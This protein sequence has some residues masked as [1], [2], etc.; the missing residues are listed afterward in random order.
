MPQQ[1]WRKFSF[2]QFIGLKFATKGADTSGAD[3][4]LAGFDEKNGFDR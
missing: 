2:R 4:A 3:M 1:V